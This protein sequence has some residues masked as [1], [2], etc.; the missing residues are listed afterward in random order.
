[1]A[2]HYYSTD[3]ILY[4]NT[5]A[6]NK[7]LK[8]LRWFMEQKYGPEEVGPNGTWTSAMDT[9]W[10]IAETM[11]ALRAAGMTVPDDLYNLAL[12]YHF[13]LHNIEE[14]NVKGFCYN[15]SNLAYLAQFWRRAALLTGDERWIKDIYRELPATCEDHVNG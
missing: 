14:N 8:G 7:I 5:A 9:P 4:K 6:A 13:E 10:Y 11:I 12:T 2:W 3:G 15:I 1:M